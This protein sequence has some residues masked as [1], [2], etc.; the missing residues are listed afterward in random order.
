MFIVVH[1]LSKSLPC[2]SH[3]AGREM[4]QNVSPVIEYE[5]ESAIIPFVGIIQK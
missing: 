2:A 4:I 3:N 5:A 1:Y